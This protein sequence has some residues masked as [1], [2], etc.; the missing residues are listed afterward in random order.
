VPARLKFNIIARATDMLGQT[1]KM[2]AS[3]LLSNAF[4]DGTDDMHRI[5]VRVQG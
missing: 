3:S 2:I 5:S 1:Q 4:P